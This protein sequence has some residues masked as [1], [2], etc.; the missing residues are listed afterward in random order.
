MHLP[1]HGAEFGEFVPAGIICCHRLDHVY[2]NVSSV[3]FSCGQV[4]GRGGKGGGEVYL[5]PCLRDRGIEGVLACYG[6]GG[7]STLVGLPAGVVGG[8]GV[9]LSGGGHAGLG[10]CEGLPILGGV[11]WSGVGDAGGEHA[12]RTA[13]DG[14]LAYGGVVGGEVLCG[15]FVV[16]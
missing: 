14:G 2:Y 3:I 8:E 16:G 9:A 12:F 11:G 15:H 6:G 13:V 5:I 1:W 4:G 10:Y 7:A